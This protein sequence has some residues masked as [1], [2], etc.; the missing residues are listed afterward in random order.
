MQPANVLEMMEEKKCHLIYIHFRCT[1]MLALFFLSLQY[2][3]LFILKFPISPSF[4]LD[5][6]L[7]T[8]DRTVLEAL[9]DLYLDQIIKDELE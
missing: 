1:H 4:L 7:H 2:Q 5:V 6:I 9:I 8:T 3:Q